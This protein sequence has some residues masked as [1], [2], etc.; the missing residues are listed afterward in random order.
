[1]AY[2]VYRVVRFICKKLIYQP[3]VRPLRYLRSKPPYQ[4][5]HPE[6]EVSLPRNTMPNALSAGPRRAGKT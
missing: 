3:F 1:M 5:L 4:E 2:A 6:D